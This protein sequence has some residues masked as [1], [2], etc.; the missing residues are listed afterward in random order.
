MEL[1][2]KHTTLAEF[3]RSRQWLILCSAGVVHMVSIAGVNTRD[4]KF[5]AHTAQRQNGTFSKT[6]RL[7][8]RASD[9]AVEN[10]GALLHRLQTKQFEIR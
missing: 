1:I 8:G 7:I 5:Y 2:T 6:V 10:R 4:G 3:E 9:I